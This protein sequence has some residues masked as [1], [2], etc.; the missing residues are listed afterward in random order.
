MGQEEDDD[1]EPCMECGS[2]VRMKKERDRLRAENAR[3]REALA[4]I[5]EVS[6]DGAAT[7]TARDALEYK[8][9]RT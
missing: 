7:Q 8:Q 2:T 1:D 4:H 6:S 9:E 3:L 5:A